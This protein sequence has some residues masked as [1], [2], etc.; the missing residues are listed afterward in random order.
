MLELLHVQHSKSFSCTGPL[1]ACQGCSAGL[2]RAVTRSQPHASW[3]GATGIL[4]I[5]TGLHQGRI[6]VSGEASIVLHAIYGIKHAIGTWQACWHTLNCGSCHGRI[7]KRTHLTVCMHREASCTI[8]TTTQLTLVSSVPMFWPR[9][10]RCQSRMAPAGRSQRRYS[11]I[12]P[13][14]EGSRQ[15][16]LQ[17]LRHDDLAGLWQPLRWLPHLL[18][19]LR[20]SGWKN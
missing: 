5:V 16:A 11:C 6:M 12:Q 8:A 18:I 1:L 7:A 19:P 2:L 10:C 4:H 20:A 13:R 3:C 15:E 14:A 9:L 17:Q